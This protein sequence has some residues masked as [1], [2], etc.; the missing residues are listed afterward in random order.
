MTSV[1]PL[2]GISLIFIQYQKGVTGKIWSI[3]T[4]SFFTY[5]SLK[6]HL[7][8]LV[9]WYI[10]VSDT[11][12]NRAWNIHGW[13]LPTTSHYNMIFLNYLLHHNSNVFLQ[14]PWQR[15]FGSKDTRSDRRRPVSLRCSNEKKSDAQT[16]GQ[17]NVANWNLERQWGIHNYNSKWEAH[18]LIW[19]HC[20]VNK[21]L[22]DRMRRN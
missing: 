14:V 5:S 21:Q 8:F 13:Q 12:R 18:N 17:L 22:G 15:D 6:M 20:V 10:C 1:W 11:H 2:Q 19:T 3:V 9:N 4:M 7:M 16:C